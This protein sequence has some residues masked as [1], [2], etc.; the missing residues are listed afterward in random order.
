MLAGAFEVQAE[1]TYIAI[2]EDLRGGKERLINKL[3]EELT[4]KTG[5]KLPF[6]SNTEAAALNT[7]EDTVIT[8]GEKGLRIVMSGEGKSKIVAAFI[9]SD[10]FNRVLADFPQSSRSLTAVYS[11]PDPMKQLA[12]AVA[13]YGENVVVG[14]L[15]SDLEGKLRNLCFSLELQPCKAILTP[16]CLQK[17][18]DDAINPNCR[19][20]FRFLDGLPLSQQSFS[21]LKQVRQSKQQVQL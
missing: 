11:D 21:D 19:G 7:D 15:T 1:E 18:S 3:R 20:I 12:L 9:S 2:G 16:F 5:Y 8:L 10:S 4:N 13:L 17:G 14:F 6:I